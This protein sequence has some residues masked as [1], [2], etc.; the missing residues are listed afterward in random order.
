MPSEAGSTYSTRF[1][2]GQSG[3][4]RGRPRG[5]RNTRATVRAITLAVVRGEKATVEASLVRAI[6]SP[7]HV[8]ALL[9]L[10]ARL[11][12]ELGPNADQGPGLVQIL[13]NTPV[14]LDQLGPQRPELHEGAHGPEEAG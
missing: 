6:R 12:R 5:S 9:D 14:P 11:N 13:L 7:R 10:T 3:N 1:R 4:P 2:A 8:I